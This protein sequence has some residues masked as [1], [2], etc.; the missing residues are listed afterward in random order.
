MYATAHAI[1]YM[2]ASF[3]H[4]ASFALKPSSMASLYPPPPFIPP[5]LLLHAP[6]QRSFGTAP[7]SN[8]HLRRRASKAFF[9]SSQQQTV[10]GRGTGNVPVADSD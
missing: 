9:A 2:T 10:T 5:G 7:H 4:V 1:T 6:R 8:G 3:L